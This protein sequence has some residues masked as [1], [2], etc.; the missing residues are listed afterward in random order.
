MKKV[1]KS[2]IDM[3]KEETKWSNIKCSIKKY[4]HQKLIMKQKIKAMN[5]QTTVNVE[6]INPININNH[7]KG[8]WHKY[9]S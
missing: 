4:E 3:L 9:V 8:Q 6:D 5:W 1:K 2:V 7:F